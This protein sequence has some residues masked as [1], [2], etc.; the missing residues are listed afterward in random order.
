MKSILKVDET[1]VKIL[2]ALVKDAR[3]KIAE[4]AKSCGLSSPAIVNRINNLK[5]AGVILGSA[6]FFDVSY[7]GYSYPAQIGISLASDQIPRVIGFLEKQ[8]NVISVSKCIGK[9]DLDVFIMAKNIEQVDSLRRAI[10]AH[11]HVGKTTLNLWSNPRLS[12]SNVE[13]KLE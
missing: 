6:A 11:A 10:C 9:H 2:R 1:D 7:L 13:M 5:E 12:F 8:P 4:I 3:T